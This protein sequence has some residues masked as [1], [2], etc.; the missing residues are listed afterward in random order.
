MYDTQAIALRI[1]QQAKEKQI[2]MKVLLSN[3]GL[4]INTVS[5]FAKGQK[6]SCISLALIADE[7]GCSVDYL[8]GRANNPEDLYSAPEIAARIKS[9]AKQ[10]GRSL[11]DVLSA[12]GLGA[13]TFSHMLHGHALASDSLALI[14]DELD[15]SVDF[16]L[17]RTASPKTSNEP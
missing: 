9:Y 16:L 10:Q 13:N 15:C 3:C 2:Q 5:D 7:L 17:G 1:K 8:L 14:A 4:N 6:L 11:D 12:C